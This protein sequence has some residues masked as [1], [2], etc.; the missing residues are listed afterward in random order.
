MQQ[1]DFTMRLIDSQEKERMRIAGEL[2]DSLG[3][4]IML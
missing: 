2:H 4:N 3:Q 1:Q